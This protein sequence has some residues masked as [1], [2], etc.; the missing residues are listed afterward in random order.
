MFTALSHDRAGLLWFA[1]FVFVMLCSPGLIYL[2][3]HS[4]GPGSLTAATIST[5]FVQIVAFMASATA[6]LRR[7]TTLFA[8]I[9]APLEEA[10]RKADKKL[11]EKRELLFEEEKQLRQKVDELKRQEEAAHSRLEAAVQKTIEAERNLHEL[12]QSRTLSY[13]V[14]ERRA[15]TDYRKHLGLL[16]VVRQDFELLVDRVIKNNEDKLSA[17]KLDRIILYIDDLDRC[18]ADKVVDV[19]QAVHLLL[20][21]PLFVVVVGVDARWLLNSLGLHYKE[22]GGAL[23]DATIG[24]KVKQVVSPQ[25]YLEK[26]FQIPY[27][28]RPMNRRGYGQL[29]SQLMGNPKSVAPMDRISSSTQPTNES[30]ERA[31]SGSSSPVGQAAVTATGAPESQE[32]EPTV[33][34]QT[35]ALGSLPPPEK[36]NPLVAVAE[37]ALVLQSWE[38]EFAQR[39]YDLIPSPRSA[40]RL[41]N[42][43]RVL[44]A[45]VESTA[46]AEFEGAHDAPGQFQL[47]LLLLAVLICDADEANIWFAQLIAQADQADGVTL[48]AILR[49]GQNDAGSP[50][51]RLMSAVTRI[52]DG[53]SFP[54]DP[55]L[56]RYW[57]PRVA[58]FSFHAWHGVMQD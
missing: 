49:E 32:Q 52:I 40:K 18:P 58:R 20:A 22:F 15:S 38:V 14:A 37:R 21:Y 51:A 46:L 3:H 28:L 47:P 54:Q 10:K 2:I 27:A 57:V 50:R 45:G 13:F 4:L 1:L 24:G 12:E 6:L 30:L 11:A 5:I 8:S 36:M 44:K 33:T 53:A 25:H 9:L 26:I 19:L 56:L 48:T 41:I 16:S 55:T 17:Q 39:L 35:S 31:S 43:Y 7:G 29:I 23:D 34:A 42:V